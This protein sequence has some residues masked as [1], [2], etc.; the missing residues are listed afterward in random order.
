MTLFYRFEDSELFV[1]IPA[2]IEDGQTLWLKINPKQE[3]LV[4]VKVD[5]YFGF[6]RDGLNVHSDLKVNLLEAFHGKIISVQGLTKILQVK[7]PPGLS[8]HSVLKLPNQGFKT[9]RSY[10][11]SER[12]DHFIHITIDASDC[13]IEKKSSKETANL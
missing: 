6:R 1:D 5:E 2:G 8:S 9:S 3:A 11:D 10:V 13:C 4:Q 12:G 7:L